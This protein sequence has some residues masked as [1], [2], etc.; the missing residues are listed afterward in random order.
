ME[1]KKEDVPNEKELDEEG[2][3]I[4]TIDATTNYGYVC[5]DSNPFD[6]QEFFSENIFNYKLYKIKFW[7]FKQD[8]LETIGGIQMFYKDR[9][10]GE[11]VSPGV[12]KGDKET[13][14]LDKELVLEPTEY[15]TDFHIGIGNQVNKVSWLEFVTSKKRIF[16]VGGTEGEEKITK[17]KEK[18]VIILAGHGGYRDTLHSFGVYYIKKQ[19]YYTVLFSGIFYLR[20]VLKKDEQFKKNTLDKLS[21]YDK[22]NQ[23][24]VKICLL[25]DISFVAVMRYALF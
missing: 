22:A 6:D 11:V 8:Y 25:P 5:P 23:A 7:I 17:L 24:L 21:T 15:I 13:N 2:K 1:T 18:N 9:Q 19:Q 12:F 14:Q 20:Y 3:E 16:R 4:I 10:T